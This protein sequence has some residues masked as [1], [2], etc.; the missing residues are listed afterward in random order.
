MPSN[1]FPGGGESPPISGEWVDR[2]FREGPASISDYADDLIGVLDALEV[3]RAVICGLSMGGYIAFDL[4][5]RYRKRVAGLI[6]ISTRAEEDTEDIRRGRDES[7]ARAAADGAVAIADS[8]LPRLF[9][10]QSLTRIPGTVAE[11]RNGILGM[12]VPGILAALIALRDRPDSRPLLPTLGDIPTLVIA[13]AADA[14]TP[15][16][17]MR[18]MAEAI[19]GAEYVLVEGAGHLAPLEQPDVTTDTIARFLQK[20]P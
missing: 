11:V 15:P 4:V 12:A 13:G 7:A 6:L 10:P 8:M 18:A 2:R 16:K 9:A 20:L 1:T 14:I 5:R 17:G 19:P 3:K